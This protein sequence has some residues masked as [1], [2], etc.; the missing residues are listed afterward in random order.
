MTNIPNL[1]GTEGVL[2]NGTLILNSEQS[3]GKPG[4]EAHLG[5]TLTCS[6]HPLVS[7]ASKIYCSE[8]CTFIV[9]FLLFNV[10]AQEGNKI[11]P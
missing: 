4:Q 2:R 11:N 8:L 7:Y 10:N 1:L 9:D 5:T 6:I 3:W